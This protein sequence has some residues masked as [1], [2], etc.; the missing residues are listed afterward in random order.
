MGNVSGDHQDFTV[1]FGVSEKLITTVLDRIATG[2][3]G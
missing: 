1:K 2:R 3:F